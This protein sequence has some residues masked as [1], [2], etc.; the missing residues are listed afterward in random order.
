MRAGYPAR[1]ARSEHACAGPHRVAMHLRLS[2]VARA[3][4]A[5]ASGALARQPQPRSALNRAARFLYACRLSREAGAIRARLRGAP[6]RSHASARVPCCTGSLWIR[7]RGRGRLNSSLDA[8][9]L[10]MP[11]E[12]PVYD[13]R[14]L[15]CCRAANRKLVKRLDASRGAGVGS[16]TSVAETSRCDSGPSRIAFCLPRREAKEGQLLFQVAG[17]R[18]Q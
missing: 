9:S 11:R 16:P 13:A 1:Q 10:L 14:R 17:S 8:V 5:A 6:P 7:G 15:M 12:V 4:R 18:R 2:P 3:A